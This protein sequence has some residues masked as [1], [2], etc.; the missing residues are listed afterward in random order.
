M[1]A[2]FGA[3]VG[4]RAALLQQLEAGQQRLAQGRAQLQRYHE[5]A[6]GELLQGRDEVLHLRARLEAACHDVLQGVRGAADHWDPLLGVR[7]WSASP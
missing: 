2:H 7:G 6:G 4:V 3:L 5:E 1:L